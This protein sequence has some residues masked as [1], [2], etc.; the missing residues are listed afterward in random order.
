MAKVYV[1]KTNLTNNNGTVW[2]LDAKNPTNINLIAQSV[3]DDNSY[4]RRDVMTSNIAE[5]KQY[6]TKK[7]AERL[8]PLLYNKIWNDHITKYDR[9][10]RGHNA[11]DWKKVAEFIGDFEIVEYDVAETNNEKVKK[12]KTTITFDRYNHRNC[13]ECGMS[14]KM[15]KYQTF[16][17]YKNTAK[18][19]P[20]CM[21][22]MAGKAEQILKSMDQELMNEHKAEWFGNKL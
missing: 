9:W 15:I 10:Q 21:E 13:S 2:Y 1:Y 14:L 8:R 3:K 19:C 22:V 7:N 18:I 12:A 17:G 4:Y 11:I 16:G 6:T 5:A 20:F